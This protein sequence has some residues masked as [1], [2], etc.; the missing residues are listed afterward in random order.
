M[1]YIREHL[2]RWKEQK[3]KQQ[4]QQQQQQQTQQQRGS[5]SIGN[6]QQQSQQQRGNNDKIE[7][8]VDEEEEEKQK[9]YNNNNNNNNDDDH[10]V[11][12]LI[13]SEEEEEAEDEQDDDMEQDQDEEEDEDDEEDEDEEEDEEDDNCEQDEEQKET[14]DRKEY[15]YKKLTPAMIDRG[16]ITNKLIRYPFFDEAGIEKEVGFI[17]DVFNYNDGV[18]PLAAKLAK[19]I[20]QFNPTIPDHHTLEP[21]DCAMFQHNDDDWLFHANDF[22][23]EKGVDWRVFRILN[24]ITPSVSVPYQ[25]YI[26][27]HYDATIRRAFNNT[28]TWE[29]E[30]FFENKFICEAW[31]YHQ[32]K[33]QHF[34]RKKA[35]QQH[36]ELDSD[37][38]DD[39][40]YNNNNN[41]DNDIQQERWVF[42]E[43]FEDPDLIQKLK[44]N[45]K[46]KYLNWK[47]WKKVTNYQNKHNY[48]DK[49][50]AQQW[51]AERR[52]LRA[53]YVAIQYKKRYHSTTK[54]P[55]SQLPDTYNDGVR[56]QVRVMFD[57]TFLW[58]NLYQKSQRFGYYQCESTPGT[59]MD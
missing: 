50:Y 22:I 45:R 24:E 23:K 40:N 10:D 19:L 1:D 39:D 6:Q 35:A 49:F 34:E 27:P 8:D 20:E 48:E 53:Y 56:L 18:N 26:N 31:E 43:R 13:E 15:F 17:V 58:G 4:Q 7:L 51:Y 52:V 37:Y 11:A 47:S 46:Y 54:H 28:R 36:M 59:K 44:Q 3:K 38:V 2:V 42:N 32:L 5:I 29:T 14:Y 30:E 21:N 25:N 33:K 55:T 9:Y 12:D 16:K 57:L 41:N